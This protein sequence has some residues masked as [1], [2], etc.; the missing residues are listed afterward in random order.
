MVLI[1][2]ITRY[3]NNSAGRIKINSKDIKKNDV[4]IV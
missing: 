4:F 2:I 1:D 3:I